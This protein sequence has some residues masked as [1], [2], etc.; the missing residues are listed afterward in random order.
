MSDGF[1]DALGGEIGPHL[2]DGAIG[3][4]QFGA[5]ILAREHFHLALVENLDIGVILAKRHDLAVQHLHAAPCVARLRV[6]VRSLRRIDVPVVRC[7]ALFLDFQHLVERGRDDRAARLAR[8]EEFLLVDFLRVMRVADEDDVDAFVAPLQEQM[9]QHVEALGEV[10]LAL[11]HRAGHVHQAEHDGLAGRN[12][13]FGEGIEA[14]I[15][16]DR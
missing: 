12:G 13:L 3:A 7:V 11:A 9:Q 6:A 15:D 8:I 14:H 10:F 5:G 4:P 2:G 1:G 16:R